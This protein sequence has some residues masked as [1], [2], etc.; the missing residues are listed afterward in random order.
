MSV[1]IFTSNIANISYSFH[2]V[3]WSIIIL[4]LLNRHISLNENEFTILWMGRYE[5][6]SVDTFNGGSFGCTA[7]LRNRVS[8]TGGFNRIWLFVLKHL[9]I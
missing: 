5:I 7:G 2:Y 4:L 6:G 3:Y 9:R 8:N 1:C